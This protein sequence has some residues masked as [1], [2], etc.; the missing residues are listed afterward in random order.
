MISTREY[1]AAQAI[2]PIYADLSKNN[3]VDFD[4]IARLAFA[5]ADKMLQQSGSSA[6][7]SETFRFS[8]WARL[9]SDGDIGIIH[10]SKDE[11]LLEAHHH[12]VP[13]VV[14]VYIEHDQP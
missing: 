1:F 8:G 5:M 3:E 6:D 4:V 10:K 14:R 11:L 12:D 7:K 2:G 9:Y 13:E